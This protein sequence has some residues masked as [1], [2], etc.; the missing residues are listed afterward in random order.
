[1]AKDV[2]YA[3]RRETGHSH[4][5]TPYEEV[6]PTSSA[7]IAHRVAFVAIPWSAQ[8]GTAGPTVKLVGG[9]RRHQRGRLASERRPGGLSGSGANLSVKSLQGGTAARSDGRAHER[10]ADSYGDKRELGG[11]SPHSAILLKSVL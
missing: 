6:V 4:M 10:G 8:W 11:V 7:R 1:M 2:P 3:A 9:V 5:R